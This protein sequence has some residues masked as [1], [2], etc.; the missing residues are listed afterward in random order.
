MERKEVIVSEQELAR[1]KEFTRKVR[2]MNDR[3]T[4]TPLSAYRFFDFLQNSSC[5]VQTPAS[6]MYLYLSIAHLRR[7]K[8][9]FFLKIDFSQNSAD[10]ARLPVYFST[11]LGYDEKN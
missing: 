11:V 10:S 2:E 5:L 8:H 9:K 4:R 1:Q 6:L 7:R 3:R